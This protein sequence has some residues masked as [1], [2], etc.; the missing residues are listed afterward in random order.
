MFKVGQK[1]LF[2]DVSCH[3]AGLP[4]VVAQVDEENDDCPFLVAFTDEDGNRETEWCCSDEIE[5]DGEDEP[6]GN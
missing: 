1:V 2:T 4:G 3:E 6:D 5:A